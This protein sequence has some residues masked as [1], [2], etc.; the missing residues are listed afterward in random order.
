LVKARP[1]TEDIARSFFPAH[2]RLYHSTSSHC[3]SYNVLAAVLSKICG[4][5][6]YD[7]YHAFA[8]EDSKSSPGFQ[9]RAKSERLE[10]YWI[11]FAFT[12]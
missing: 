11:I 9:S 10:C 4:A 12:N 3:S 6:Q 7:K 1:L 2:N 5:S 8:S